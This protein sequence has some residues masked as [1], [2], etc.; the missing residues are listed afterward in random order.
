MNIFQQ[1]LVGIGL[2]AILAGCSPANISDTPQPESSET[3]PDEMTSEENQT[4]ME[5]E[6]E[7]GEMSVID[8]TVA[9]NEVM[10]SE[11]QVMGEELEFRVSN[12]T[13]DPLNMAIVKTTLAQSD[14]KVRQGRIH[15]TQEGVEVISEL[16]DRPVQ[17]GE[18]RI[19]EERL[20]PGEYQMVVTTEN[21]SEPLAVA[22]FTVNP[23]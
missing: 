10:L 15:R 7:R 12:E 6:A 11:S 8:V 23:K 16:S 2:V 18:T 1:G 4:P 5:D 3:M 13:S 20:E 19:V 9:N 22:I 21:L 17:A 14:I